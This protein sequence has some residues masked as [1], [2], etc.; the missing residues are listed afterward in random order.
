MTVIRPPFNLAEGRTE[1]ALSG[2]CKEQNESCLEVVFPGDSGA[3]APQFVER[4]EV[5]PMVAMFRG[6]H[7]ASARERDICL[8]GLL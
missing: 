6:A 2:G 4:R 7:D 5:S 1:P 3:W 8:L